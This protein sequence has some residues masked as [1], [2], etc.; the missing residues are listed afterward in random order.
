MMQPLAVGIMLVL[1]MGHMLPGCHSRTLVTLIARA[2][3]AQ[4][5]D[6]MIHHV[7]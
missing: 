1:N 5:H 2:C 4:L 6:M 7:A 3:L